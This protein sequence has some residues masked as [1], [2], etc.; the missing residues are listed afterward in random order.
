MLTLDVSKSFGR[1]WAV[2]EYGACGA[3]MEVIRELRPFSFAGSG[4]TRDRTDE[5]KRGRSSYQQT[6]PL[7]SRRVSQPPSDRVVPQAIVHL[8]TIVSRPRMQ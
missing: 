7:Q 3:S 5:R 8:S 4:P 1:L 6:R 2:V